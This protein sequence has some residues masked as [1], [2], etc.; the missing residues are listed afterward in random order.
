MVLPCSV[1]DLVMA[2]AILFDLALGDQLRV[3]GYLHLPR[4]PIEPM[5]L[6]VTELRVLLSALLLGQPGAP[7][8]RLIATTLT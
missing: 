5:F 1:A 7:A 8:L 4:T 2:A 3:T 6:V